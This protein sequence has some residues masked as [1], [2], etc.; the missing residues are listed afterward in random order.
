MIKHFI[1]ILEIKKA[2]TAEPTNSETGNHSSSVKRLLANYPLVDIAPFIKAATVVIEDPL[3]N[4]ILWVPM[5]EA[6]S[7]TI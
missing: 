5:T 2:F 6:T 4:V 1:V 3:T 7:F